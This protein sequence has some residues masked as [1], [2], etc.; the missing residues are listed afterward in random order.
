MSM[1]LQNT[2][3][4]SPVAAFIGQLDG[5]P[6][7]KSSYKNADVVSIPFGFPLAYKPSPTTDQDVY[8]PAA[9]TDKVASFLFRA[10]T[11]SRAWTDE[12]GTHGELDSTGVRPGIEMNGL[13]QGRIWV[14]CTT[15]C[16]PGDRLFVAYS[17][18]STY[19]AAGQLG[20]V[21]EASHTLDDSNMGRW[22]S[23]ATAGQGAW[24]RLDL[25]NK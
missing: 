1:T 11:Y 25:T 3:L 17:A 2:Y 9:S 22:E 10:D 6:S 15:G 4:D 20:N 5:G 14:T 23:T 7:I 16:A 8:V 18:G 24:L 19:T 21:A 13:I 12:N